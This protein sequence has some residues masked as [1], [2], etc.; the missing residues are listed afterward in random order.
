[1]EIDDEIGESPSGPNEQ[2]NFDSVNLIGTPDGWMP[3]S[4]PLVSK[5]TDPSQVTQTRKML[6]ILR[7]EYVYL[8][9]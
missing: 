3:P 8:Y 7:V 6:T 1:M 4:A 2:M 9:T 5:V